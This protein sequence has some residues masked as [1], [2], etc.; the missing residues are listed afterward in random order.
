MNLYF[1]WLVSEEVYKFKPMDITWR[2]ARDPELYHSIYSLPD[3]IDL[4]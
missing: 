2:N 4:V 1:D 3:Y